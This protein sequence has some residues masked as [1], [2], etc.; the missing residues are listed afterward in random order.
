M[1]VLEDRNSRSPA[2]SPTTPRLTAKVKSAI[3][4]DAGA[5]TCGGGE[6]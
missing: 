6:R 3:A 2:S 5:R 1:R 4:T